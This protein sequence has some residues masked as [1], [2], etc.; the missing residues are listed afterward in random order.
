M[1]NMGL[2]QPEH[3]PYEAEVISTLIAEVF[4]YVL[5]SAI[6]ETFIYATC[7]T[8]I[9]YLTLQTQSRQRQNVKPTALPENAFIQANVQMQPPMQ[10]TT[11][12]IHGNV[13]RKR[14]V[15]ALAKLKAAAERREVAD[16][17]KFNAAMAKLREEENKL[18]IAAQR[19][20]KE[21]EEKRQGAEER[22]KAIL[23]EKKLAA[24]A[25]KRA[26]EEKKGKLK[27]TNL[28]LPRQKG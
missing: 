15:L 10:E 17:A 13:H 11:A 5:C 4:L 28:H 23:E 14:E 19:R 1:H 27:R 8:Q 2:S 18:M 20:N 16:Q 12:T 9:Q 3:T 21:M 7:I 24:E 22:K 26:A 25:R 6:F